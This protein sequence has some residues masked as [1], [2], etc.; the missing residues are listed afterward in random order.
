MKNK[1][2]G[3]YAITQSI[4]S[5]EGRG[6]LDNGKIEITVSRKP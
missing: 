4:S 1:K 3:N 5:S 2:N 6:A